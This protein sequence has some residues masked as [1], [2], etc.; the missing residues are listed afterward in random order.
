MSSWTTEVFGDT[1]LLSKDGYPV[2][3]ASL[4]SKKVVGI[5]FSAH[6]CPPCRGFTPVLAKAHDEAKLTAF[7]SDFEIVFVSSD[8][9]ASSFSAYYSEMPWLALPFEQ[10]DRKSKISSRFG[11]RGIPTL[12]FLDGKTGEVLTSNGRGVVSRERGKFLGTFISGA[13]NAAAP[14]PRPPPS[15]DS[16][17]GI[18]TRDVFGDARLLSKEDGS[19]TPTSTLSSKKIVGIYFS[20]HWCPPCRG[21]TPVLARAYEMAKFK[22]YGDAF[23]IV[24]VSSDQDASSFAEYYSEMPWLALP[25]DQSD[26]KKKISERFGIRGIPKLVFLDGNTGKVL[27]SD[28]RG[29]VSRSGGDFPTKVLAS[30]TATAHNASSGPVCPTVTGSRSTEMK[31]VGNGQ[32]K[33]ES[34]VSVPAKEV[35][36][37]DG[38]FYAR[39]HGYGATGSSFVRLA[40]RSADGTMKK[41][42]KLS[43]VG[44]ES[45]RYVFDVNTI[46]WDISPTDVVHL[47]AVSPPWEGWSCAIESAGVVGHLPCGIGGGSASA[48]PS[49][50]SDGIDDASLSVSK[51]SRCDV[52]GNGSWRSVEYLT[53]PVCRGISTIQGFVNAKDQGHGGT[54]SSYVR[55]ALRSPT[56]DL[57]SEHKLS[58]V[59][60]SSTRYAIDVDV[61]STWTDFLSKAIPGEDTISLEPVSAPW[62]AWEC[63]IMSGALRVNR[64]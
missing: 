10:R 46:G 6:W 45:K 53:I 2:S 34:Y 56:G 14:P 16:S 18:W 41:E 37:V 48:A 8:S 54:G 52:T 9:D 40:L 35:V 29:I 63:C 58:T 43:V 61:R 13:A 59:T 22:G 30:I 39:D 20:A 12:V 7:G 32:W 51:S 31:V 11:V 44:P 21:F 55:L 38:I 33:S 64:T 49:K 50:S 4:A 24:F 23:E 57:K 28:G 36:S 62:P 17:S 5:Y 15:N 1:S 27:T 26:R 3:A 60:H 47:E 19:G 42:H 25:F